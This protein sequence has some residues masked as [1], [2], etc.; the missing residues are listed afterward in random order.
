MSDSQD[1]WSIISTASTLEKTE[2]IVIIVGEPNSGKST[3]AAFLSGLK[4]SADKKPP[5]IIDYTYGKIPTTSGIKR[6][7]H[8]Y[9]IG[10]C[11]DTVMILDSI[12]TKQLHNFLVIVT[13][14]LSEPG[15]AFDKIS[16]TLNDLELY[17]PKY[18]K[19]YF[20][21]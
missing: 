3:I 8:I 17:I 2:R 16:K 13:M 4:P 21:K 7:L 11:N 6:I 5:Y 1:I 12:V 15:K 20:I 18:E 14:D 9:E 19:R 10:E